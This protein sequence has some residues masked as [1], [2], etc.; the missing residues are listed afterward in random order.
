LN[1]LDR[2]LLHTTEL[3]PFLIQFHHPRESLS[4]A[5]ML[6]SCLPF[7][8]PLPVPVAMTAATGRALP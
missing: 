1:R 7:V 8:L 3:R 2:L 6:Q 4:H 5:H